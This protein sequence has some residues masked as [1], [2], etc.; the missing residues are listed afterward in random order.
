[1]ILQD[2]Q[3]LN[4]FMPSLP[5]E[6]TDA[7]AEVASRTSIFQGYVGV[8][9]VAFLVTLFATP[10]MRRLAVKNKIVDLPTDPRKVHK[11]PTAYLG[12]V[13][14]FLGLMGAMVFSILATQFPGLIEYHDTESTLT[15]SSKMLP[16]SI[17]LGM[18]VI[19]F[20]GL[21][22]DIMGISPRLKISGQLFAAAALAL[23]QVGVRV[24]AGLILPIASFFGVETVSINNVDTIGIAFGMNTWFFGNGFDIIYWTGAAVITIF[25]LGGCNAANLI[26]GLDGLLSGVTAIAAAGIL[27]IALTMALFDDGPRDTQRVIL[28]L[29]IVGA[30]L[31][32]LPHNFNPAN[33]FLGDSGSLLLGYC[34]VVLILMLGDTG[35]THLV[36]AG[37]VVFAIPIMDTAL[38]IIRRKLS[39]KKMSDADANHLHHMLKRSLGVKG[40]VFV[41]YGIGLA[42]AGLGIA[43]SFGRARVIYAV[44]LVLASFIGV[45]AIKIARRNAIEAEIVGKISKAS[46]TPATDSN[47]K[48]SDD[49][50]P[51]AKR[52]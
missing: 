17:L 6:E 21:F 41:L 12:G 35:K 50:S 2:S 36:V 32:F 1:M 10:I 31:G 22:D 29:A 52:G 51:A 34:M 38:A 43:A 47:N 44:I 30:C 45:T 46:A 19:M 33:I 39:G 16:F 20:V 8:F 28:A 26:D 18:T 24:A 48:T 15:A 11:Q 3:L 42:F 49:Q 14:V 40:A 9:I 27:V 5:P 13:A 7:I 4:D 25:V 37:L 23:D